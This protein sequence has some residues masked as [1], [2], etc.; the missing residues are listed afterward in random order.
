MRSMGLGH[1]FLVLLFAGWPGLVLAQGSPNTEAAQHFERGLSLAKQKAY[2]EAIAEFNRAYQI[3]PHFSVMYNLGQAYIAIDQPVYAVEA[4]RRYLAE[5]GAEVPPAR[6]EQ[7]EDAILEQERRIASLTL[8]SELAGAVVRIDGSEVGR[9]PLAG[10]IRIGAG[11][12]V[13]DA[14]LPGYK[15]WEQRLALAGQERRTL[16]IRFEPAVVAVAP[17]PTTPD[18]PPVVVATPTRVQPSAAP[19]PSASAASP[20]IPPQSSTAP[21]PTTHGAASATATPNVAMP[22]DSSARASSAAPRGRART[23]AALVVGAVGVGAIATGSMF[24][25]QAFAKKSDSDK[26]CPNE[27]CTRTGVHLNDQARDAATVSTISFGVG[28]VAIGVATY[29][30]FWP[31]AAASPPGPSVSAVEIAPALGPGHTGLNLRGVW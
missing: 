7:V 6:R 20:P 24:G 15:G 18:V 29:L 21:A 25:V 30:L 8:R 13:V 19:E 31:R 10:P 3:S 9:T 5:G 28:V 11:L 2:S 23:I 1:F 16:D 17:P 22:A 14:S 4:M 27:Q 26:Q 12:H